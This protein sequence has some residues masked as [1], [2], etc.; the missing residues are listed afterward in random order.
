MGKMEKAVASSETGSAERPLQMK[1]RWATRADAAELRRIYAYYVE[2]TTVSFEYEAPSVA[3]TERRIAEVEG[4]YPFLVCV[5]ESE[6]GEDGKEGGNAGNSSVA[7]NDEAKKAL[8]VA[9]DGEEKRDASVALDSE[10][11]EKAQDFPS[12]TK[13]KH[14]EAREVLPSRANVVDGKNVENEGG[15]RIVGY[16][17]A[18]RA[19]ERAAY[20]WTAETAVYVDRNWRRHG[21]GEA[22]YSALIEILEAQG[23]RTLYAVVVA[24]NKASVEFHKRAGYREFATFKNAGWKFERW[25]DV[26]WLER[27]LG[28]WRDAENINEK[29]G[30]PEKADKSPNTSNAEA[31]EPAPTPV[32][33]LAELAE[34]RSAAILSAATRKATL[35][36]R[37][38]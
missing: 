7:P 13:R 35:A 8:P 28:A 26:V 9:S 21:V 30:G 3:E 19:F 15:E 34:K 25:L 18:H 24:E 12:A 23:F 32:R 36:K 5:V 4:V 10:R 14:S 2:N 37:E 22:L 38:T 1:I 11:E 6:R 17:L 31:A 20:S 33:P 16:A 29:I 27:T